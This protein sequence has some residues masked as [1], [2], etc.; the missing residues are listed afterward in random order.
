VLVGVS[1]HYGVSTSKG[2]SVMVVEAKR[3]APGSWMG[4]GCSGKW[5]SVRSV[6]HM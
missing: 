3:M 6:K 5:L 4:L 1:A 2:G